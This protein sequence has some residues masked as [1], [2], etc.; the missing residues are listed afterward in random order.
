MATP[1]QTRQSFQSL[2]P[3]AVVVHAHRSPFGYCDVVF[4]LRTSVAYSFTSIEEE[5][6]KPSLFYRERTKKLLALLVTEIERT[7]AKLEE[8]KEKL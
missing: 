7:K 6:S 5:N 1:E 2:V 3:H 8:A 4:E